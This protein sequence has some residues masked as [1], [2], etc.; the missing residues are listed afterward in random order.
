MKKRFTELKPV[1]LSRLSDI[2]NKENWTKL[3]MKYSYFD[4]ICTMLKHFSDEEQDLLIDLTSRFLKIGIS[5]Y[6]YYLEQAL[7][8]LKKNL[9]KNCDRLYILPLLAPENFNKSKSSTH[10]HYLF[11]APE[12]KNM[13]PIKNSDIIFI[14]NPDNIMI[15]KSI[16]NYKLLLVDDFVGTGDTAE[17]AINYLKEKLNIDSSKFIILSFIALDTGIKKLKSMGIEIYCKVSKSK[18]ISDYYTASK[19]SSCILNMED[20][21]KYIHVNTEFI[22]G[23]KKSEAL[24]SLIRT[25]N[26]TF[27]V[28]WKFKKYENNMNYNP[29]FPR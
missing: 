29:P 28:F 18:G 24:V 13:L 22:F 26:N 17:S 21:E 16:K 2:F 1:V 4:K 27:P 8:K 14:D 23:Y 6:E 9:F 3:P 5:E 11:R 15:K 7:G 19:L 10:V 12:I 20:I 25:P